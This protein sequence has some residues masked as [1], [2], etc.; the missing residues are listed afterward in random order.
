MDANTANYNLKLASITSRL[1]FFT[2]DD[3]VAFVANSSHTAAQCGSPIFSAHGRELLQDLEVDHDAGINIHGRRHL[4]QT[5]DPCFHGSTTLQ[6][7]D[8]RRMRLDDPAFR[9]GPGLARTVRVQAAASDGSLHFARFYGN[10]HKP[11]YKPQPFVKISTRSS[12]LILTPGH[13]VNVAETES[14]REARLLVAA[15]VKKGHYVFI[16]H[17][18]RLIAEAV[19]VVEDVIERGSFG[20]WV[21]GDLPLV[22]GIA[23]SVATVD[24]LYS[25][26]ELRANTHWMVDVC[27]AIIYWMQQLGLFTARIL[28]PIIIAPTANP[29]LSFERLVERI[30][31]ISPSQF[32]ALGIGFVVIPALAMVRL[33]WRKICTMHMASR[34]KTI[35]LV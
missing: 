34:S 4:L 11:G 26:E 22:N 16:E 13:F 12:N 33:V 7:E 31:S 17:E 32:I 5:E 35:K 15:R 6:L 28:Y 19:T 3:C 18:G 10:T 21:E 14:W 1:G 9:H 29:R 8:G 23:A 2:Y 20:I 27:S 25:K 30:N 24:L